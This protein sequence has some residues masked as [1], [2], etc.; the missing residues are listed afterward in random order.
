MTGGHF[1]RSHW[2][3]SQIALCLVAAF[4]LSAAADNATT[5]PQQVK[6]LQAVSVAASRTEQALD[7]TAPSVEVIDRQQLDRRIAAD[8]RDLVSDEAGV[9]VSREP[10]RRGNAGV[11]IRGIGGNRILTLIDGVRQPDQYGGGGGNGAISGADYTEPESLKAVEIIKG[12]ASSLYGSDAI[13]GVM[14]YRT[15]SAADFVNAD[16]PL[17]FGVKLGGD[18]ADQSTAATLTLA[19][20][21]DLASALL[22][23]TRRHGHETD[24]QGRDDSSDGTA[25]SR[26]T[27]PNPQ[28]WDS[29]NVLLKLGLHPNPQHDLFFTY[30]R[31]QRQQDSNVISARS[32]GSPTTGSLLSQMADDDQTRERFTLAHQW[33]DKDHPWLQAAKWQIYHQTLDQTED[34][35]EHRLGPSNARLRTSDYRFAQ[36]LTGLDAQ[37]ESRFFALGAAHRL[38]YGFDASR[39]ETERLRDRTQ[40]NADGSTTKT[41]GGEPFPQKAFPDNRTDRFGLFVENQMR[42][43]NGWTVTPGLRYDYY[44]LSLQQDAL[45]QKINQNGPQASNLS[46]SAL[47]PKLALAYAFNDQ[48]TGFAQFSTGFRAPPFDDATMAFMNAAHG[49]EVLPNPN[50]KAETSRGIELGVKGRWQEVELDVSVFANRYRDFLERQLVGQRSVQGRPLATYQYGNVG[51][52]SIHGAEVKAGWRFAHHWQISGALAWAEGDNDSEGTPLA[53]V[54]PLKGHLKLAYSTEPFGADAKLRFAAAKSRVPQST[55]SRGQA[56]AGFAPAGYGVVDLTAYW[57]VNKQLRIN[58]GV[59]NVFDKTYWNW[60]DVKGFAAN[61]AVLDFYSQ[62]GRSVAGTVEYRFF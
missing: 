8:L 41:V 23:Y 11:T 38:I 46:D 62:P 44:R 40:W 17:Y 20:R 10:G 28:A 18:S 31:F 51:K 42:W 61:S 50:L 47:S 19:G 36:T 15:L 30:E 22:M 3:L 6:R 53:S 24:N 56:T 5:E 34:V 4:P 33:Q 58:A 35:R 60:S 54:E 52:V 7:E 16:N 55:D 32:S 27:T 2:T 39:T 45:S 12:P 59:F 43:D 9:S 14:A 25:A 13:G 37:L 48:I 1:S 21:N 29:D 49:Y 57:Q 26:R